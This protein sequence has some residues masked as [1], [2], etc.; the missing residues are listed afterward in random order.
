M[1][2]FQLIKYMKN[3][4]CLQQKCYVF[5]IRTDDEIWPIFTAKIIYFIHAN[6]CRLVNIYST[7]NSINN[8]M[9]LLQKYDI[10]YI[11]DKQRNMDNL[12]SRNIKF[13]A[14]TICVG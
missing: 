7:A 2:N 11:S 9:K 1:V 6:L 14:C 10:F 3:L 4:I 8:L 5:C 12:N 13:H